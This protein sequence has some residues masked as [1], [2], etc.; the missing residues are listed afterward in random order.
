MQR[1]ASSARP[2]KGAPLD[3][4]PALAALCSSSSHNQELHCRLQTLSSRQRASLLTGA[5]PKGEQLENL[6]ATRLVPSGRETNGAS[7]SRG[8]SRPSVWSPRSDPEGP[9]W[10][11]LKT[12]PRRKP[13]KAKG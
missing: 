8:Y 9:I 2:P 3:S 13:L 12:S 6:A 10:Q 11:R 5:R 7:K 4:G 1:G